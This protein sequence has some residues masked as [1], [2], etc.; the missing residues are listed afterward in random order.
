MFSMRPDLR[1]TI[2][3]SGCSFYEEGCGCANPKL[4]KSSLK[5]TMS[6]SQCHPTCMAGYMWLLTFSFQTD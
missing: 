5:A 2:L 1:V 4:P 3:V 6:P